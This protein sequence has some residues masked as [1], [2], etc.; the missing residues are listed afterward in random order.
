M[1]FL[2][3]VAVKIRRLEIHVSLWDRNQPGEHNVHPGNIGVYLLKFGID[4]NIEVLK[5]GKFSRG[6]LSQNRRNP[7]D[8]SNKVIHHYVFEMT[9]L[10]PRFTAIENIENLTESVDDDITAFNIPVLALAS[11]CRVGNLI[12]PCDKFN[13]HL[14]ENPYLV[15]AYANKS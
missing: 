12:L 5:V 2:Q 7:D 1:S 3:Y 8:L 9:S 6:E 13:I 11:N 10:V 14:Y 4:N 15:I